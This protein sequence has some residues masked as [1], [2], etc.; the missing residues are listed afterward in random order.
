MSSKSP[1][2]IQTGKK[3]KALKDP[4]YNRVK[5]VTVN[6]TLEEYEMLYQKAHKARKPVGM[7]VREFS[8]GKEIKVPVSIHDRPAVRSLQGI[9]NNVNQIAKEL[10]GQGGIRTAM[11]AE[12]IIQQIEKILENE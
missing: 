11:A 2:L 12:K 7:L 5:R 9:A 8:L 3:E 1:G 10:K 4:L 6:Y